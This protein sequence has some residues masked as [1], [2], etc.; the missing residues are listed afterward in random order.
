MYRIRST[1]D[2]RKYQSELQCV[3][4][5]GVTP[6]QVPEGP[7][8]GGVLLVLNSRHFLI[9]PLVDFGWR[10]NMVFRAQCHNGRDDPT[11]IGYHNVLGRSVVPY[12]LSVGILG[13]HFVQKIIISTVKYAITVPK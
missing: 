13:T 10:G 1:D 2:F 9:N 3:F 7:Q 11:Y 8:Y 4:A 5:A 12:I 6:S